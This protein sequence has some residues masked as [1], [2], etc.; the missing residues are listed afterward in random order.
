MAE[1]K[2]KVRNIG[3]PNIEPP[4]KICDDKNCPF[5]GNLSVR[6]RVME[7]IVTSTKMYKTVVFQTDYLSLIKKY[8]RYERR[9]SRKLAH[10]PPCIEANVGDTIK[11][12]ECRPLSKNV[13]RVVVAVTPA[14]EGAKEE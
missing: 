6:G 1:T 8:S 13:S 3:I 10:L 11:V 14:E 9:R 7:G 5:H 4:E 2:S 12:V